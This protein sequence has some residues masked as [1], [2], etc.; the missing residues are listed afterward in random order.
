MTTPNPYDQLRADVAAAEAADQ[1]KDSALAAAASALAAAAAQHAADVQE[2]A[3]LEAQIN[4][5]PP[6]PAGPAW[7]INIGTN[8]G[9]LAAADQAVGGAAAVRFYWAPGAGLRFPTSA[10]LGGD[11]GNRILVESSKIRPQDILAGKADAA[12]T[13]TAKAAPTDRPTLLCPWHEPEN[14][15]GVFTAPLFRAAFAHYAQLVHAVGNPQLMV[16]LILMG[17]TWNG[18]AGRNWRDWY[19]GP[20]SVDVFC[21]DEYAWT[22][23][24]NIAH[25]FTGLDAAAKAEGKP[26]SVTE[27]G[28]ENTQFLGQARYDAL[29]AV[30][31]R[32]RAVSTGPVA[33]YFGWGAGN[34]W[35]MTQDPRA[36]AAWKAGQTG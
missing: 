30:A 11:L 20:G 19:A 15:G 2:I 3:A 34:R 13:A 5:T 17:E 14:D 8:V 31:K 7:G 36:L 32:A 27:T 18:Q 24:T 4:P 1:A 6:P 10:D 25:M 23:G 26:A 29:T 33:M 21:T 35:D 28:V 9:K 22:T 12:I 16:A